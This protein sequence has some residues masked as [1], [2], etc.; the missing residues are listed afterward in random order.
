MRKKSAVWTVL[1][2]FLF[3]NFG[4]SGVMVRRGETPYEI[5]KK[6]PV[7]I[8]EEIIEAKM[9]I[10]SEIPS[11]PPG[12]QYPQLKLGARPQRP[13]D[14]N[15]ISFVQ[16]MAKRD[17]L[18]IFVLESPVLLDT[19]GGDGRWYRG[20]IPEGTILLGKKIKENHKITFIPTKIALCWNEVRGVR[21]VIIPTVLKIT[22]RETVI[23]R[24]RDTD[25][26]PAL[27][28]GVGGLIVGGV[29]GWLLAPGKAAAVVGAPTVI[30]R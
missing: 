27:W 30:T 29:L 11:P 18:T 5:I 6:P 23:E 20:F 8:K 7:V 28:A 12:K 16:E 21:I 24:Y 15:T 25:Y 17:G 14:K 9:E 3:F 4:C 19:K 22:E 2:F 10:V 13:V 1:S 26:T